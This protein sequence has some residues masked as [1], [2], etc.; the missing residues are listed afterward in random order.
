MKEL[1]DK[2][3]SYNIFNNLF[4]GV[5]FS[6]ILSKV[7]QYNLIQ[8]DVLVG[9]FFYFFIGNIISRVGSL[10]VEPTLKKLK[11]L[12]FVEYPILVK[13]SKVDSKIEIL[14]EV[15]NMYR[16]ICSVM[17]L[18]LLAILHEKLTSYL[19]ISIETSSVILLIIIFIMF[20][21]AYRKQTNYVRNRVIANE[22]KDK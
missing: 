16:S 11:F 4:P 12:N 20:L 14:S 22:E 10:V 5:I 2:I 8:E 13:A 15:N 6:V 18:I 19:K 3:S 17:L 7:T 21:L 1:L 9:F